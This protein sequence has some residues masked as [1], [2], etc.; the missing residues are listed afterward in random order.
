MSGASS[1]NLANAATSLALNLGLN[2][3][4]IPRYGASGAAIAWAASIVFNNLA[5]VIEVAVLLGIEPFGG[6]YFLSSIGSLLCFGLV[7]SVARWQ[8]GASL[9]A[10][11]VT[12]VIGGASYCLFLWRA[13][14]ALELDTFAASIRRIPATSMSAS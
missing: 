2:F 14:R 11:A 13:R 10:L 6:G 3:V 4:L 12:I 7:G 8:L 9:A 1:W 5:S